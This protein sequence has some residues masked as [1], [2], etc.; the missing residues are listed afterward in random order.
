MELSKWWYDNNCI[1]NQSI[2]I[3]DYAPDMEADNSS[4][5]SESEPPTGTL[6]VNGQGKG[7]VIATGDETFM[8]RYSTI[9][10]SN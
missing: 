8:G 7:V 1:S 3:I 2:R 10:N 6:V 4:L 9:N 5:T